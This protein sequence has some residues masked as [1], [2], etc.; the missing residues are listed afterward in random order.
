MSILSFINPCFLKNVFIY[1]IEFKLFLGGKSYQGRYLPSHFAL[2]LTAHLNPILVQKLQLELDALRSSLG[3][4]SRRCVGFF[5]EKPTSSS[6]PVLR[7]E[8]NRA[9][10]KTDKLHNLSSVYLEKSVSLFSFCLSVHSE[11]YTN[12]SL[13]NVSFIHHSFTSSG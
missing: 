12:D 5:E 9:V 10:E 6:V 3:D 4:V 8:L 1:G 13:S 7:A 11:I 2:F